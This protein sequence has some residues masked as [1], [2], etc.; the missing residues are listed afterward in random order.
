MS[1]AASCGVSPA[2]EA[3]SPLLERLD[4]VLPD[5]TRLSWVSE[6]AR[7]VWQPRL[8]RI[9]HAWADIEWVSILSGVRC[10]ALTQLSPEALVASA[11]RWAEH[12]LIALPL[13]VEGR[14]ESPYRSTPPEPKS[15]KPVALRVVVGALPHVVRFRRAWEASDHDEIAGFLGYPSCCRDFFRELWVK[16]RYVDTTWGMSVGTARPSLPVTTLE[17]SGPPMANI[18]WRWMGVRA[19]P[20]LPCRFDCDATVTFAERLREVGIK[21]GYAE[22]MEWIGE[23][24]SWPVEWSALHGIA[25]VKTP[26]LKVSTR[27]DATPH[28]YTVRRQGSGYPEEALQGLSFPWKTPARPVVSGSSEFQRGMDHLIELQVARPD[29]FHLDNGFSSRHA[30]ETQHRPIVTLAREQLAGAAGNVIDLGCGNGALLDRICRG[31]DGLIPWGVDLRG[32][33]LDHARQLLPNF[34]AN[35]GRQD[36][37]DSGFW[38]GARSY[39]MAIL[40]VGRLLEAPKGKAEKLLATIVA[41]CRRLLVYAYPGWA[42]EDLETLVRRAGLSVQ[43]GSTP[44]AAIAAV[45]MRADAPLSEPPGSGQLKDKTRGG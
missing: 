23:I 39:E 44:T 32:D 7:E 9:A 11:A 10:C 3:S 27:T 6:K 20:H 17:V 26:L 33:V 12:G 40:M 4:F 31:N 36:L 8:H 30:M 25:E 21:A 16:R 5:F 1:S 42:N 35:F 13:R 38:P 19:V 37:F 22:E 24:L 2:G 34:A 28:K 14:S 18:L 43:Q 29:W 45:N 41:H 15:G